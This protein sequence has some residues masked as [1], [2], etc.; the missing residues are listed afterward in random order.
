MQNPCSKSSAN[1]WKFHQTWSQN[2]SPNRVK[3]NIKRG[4]KID[5]KNDGIFH[6]R[7]QRRQLAVGPIDNLNS[8]RL[9]TE[10]KQ[11][12][13]YSENNLS[14]HNLNSLRR[15]F[16]EN[17]ITWKVQFRLE[18][19]LPYLNA[20]QAQATPSGSRLPTA[21]FRS[22]PKDSR[23]SCQDFPSLEVQTAICG[24][25]AGKG[26]KSIYFGSKIVPGGS[27]K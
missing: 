17:S 11:K 23:D 8:T 13:T 10:S 15:H 21:K 20:P 25:F 1:T 2:R 18:K 27:N 19:R 6:A 7:A 9:S 26:A 22:G 4:P 16:S 3:I 24:W 5:A 14:E 12:I